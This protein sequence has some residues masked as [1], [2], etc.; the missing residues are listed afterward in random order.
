VAREAQKR[1]AR[2]FCEPSPDCLGDRALFSLRWFGDFGFCAWRFKVSR[3]QFNSFLRVCEITFSW[4]IWRRLPAIQQKLCFA[5]NSRLRHRFADAE[6][7]ESSTAYKSAQIAKQR[8]KHSRKLDKAIDKAMPSRENVQENLLERLD[9]SSTHRKTF[10]L[11]LRRKRLRRTA[12]WSICITP[13]PICRNRLIK[14]DLVVNVHTGED[15]RFVLISRT[16][17]L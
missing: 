15:A 10:R 8:F 4:L 13:P 6:F 11:L 3:R 7:S 2:K 5:A 1:L 9:P 17:N 12:P 16:R 14:K